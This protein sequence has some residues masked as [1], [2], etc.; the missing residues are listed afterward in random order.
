ME[1][2]SPSIWNWKASPEVFR[3]SLEEGGGTGATGEDAASASG[4]AG[5]GGSA[6]DEAVLT[7]SSAV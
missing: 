1:L 2:F 4:A 6:G 5:A 3:V 7:A